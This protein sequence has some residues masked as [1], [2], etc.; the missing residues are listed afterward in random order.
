MN[1]GLQ[2]V[3]PQLST[4]LSS[5][6]VCRLLCMLLP[7]QVLLDDEPSRVIN[8]DVAGFTEQFFPIFIVVSLEILC[9]ES[10]RDF[11]SFFGFFEGLGD[12]SPLAGRFRNRSINAVG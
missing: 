4:F 3:H 12:A 2:G 5:M 11:A 1:H 7:F 9:T 10:S 8:H 6:E